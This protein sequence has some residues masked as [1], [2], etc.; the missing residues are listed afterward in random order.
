MR[1]IDKYFELND[2]SCDALVLGYSPYNI[3]GKDFGNNFYI[4]SCSDVEEAF[5][6]SLRQILGKK[7][8][9]CHWADS[10]KW[11]TIANL[12]KLEDRIHG[13]VFEVVSGDSDYQTIFEDYLSSTWGKFDSTWIYGKGSLYRFREGKREVALKKFEDY[14]NE[15]EKSRWKQIY[16]FMKK[17]THSQFEEKSTR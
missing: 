11:G 17:Y 12:D 1:E 5:G 10:A 2:R 14:W 13:G 16:E 15:K 3:L 8:G 7:S 9:A 6:Y 4:P